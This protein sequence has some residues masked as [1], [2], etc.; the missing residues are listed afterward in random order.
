MNILDAA[1][2]LASLGSVG[3]SVFSLLFAG[4][5]LARP[6]KQFGPTNGTER[7]GASWLWEL[8]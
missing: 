8:S 4:V 1:V 6:P 2:K 5:L 3:V 7:W